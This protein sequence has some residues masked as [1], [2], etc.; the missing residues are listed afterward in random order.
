MLYTLGI[1]SFPD[2]IE[3]EWV[4][5]NVGDGDLDDERMIVWL[6]GVSAARKKLSGED[7]VQKTVSDMLN[8]DRYQRITAAQMVARFT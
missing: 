5:G 4:L 3:N 7:K 8:E 6:L 1:I 2:T